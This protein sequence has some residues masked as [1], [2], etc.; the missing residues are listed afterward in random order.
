MIA[1]CFIIGQV[2]LKKKTARRKTLYPRLFAI[3]LIH[4]TLKRYL[5]WESLWQNSFVAVS[6]KMVNHHRGSLS[7]KYFQ[8]LSYLLSVVSNCFI[9]CHHRPLGSNIFPGTTATHVTQCSV[10]YPTGNL[11]CQFIMSFDIRVTW[12]SRAMINARSAKSFH[13]L[14]TECCRSSNDYLKDV[15]P[16]K[17]C[18]IPC[19]N[20]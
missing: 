15:S 9:T 8:F 13:N 2:K 19:L 1:D 12:R 16:K 17:L 3:F 10:K 7:I 5:A 6:M 14:P 20:R 4:W 18:E 11:Y